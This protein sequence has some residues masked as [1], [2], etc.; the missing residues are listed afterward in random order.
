MKRPFLFLLIL[1]LFSTLSFGQS[2][3]YSLTATDSAKRYDLVSARLLNAALD[4]YPADSFS[5]ARA[6]KM[7]G[8]WQ[9]F[10]Q[11]RVAYN[12]PD[13]ISIFDPIAVGMKTFFAASN[14]TNCLGSGGGNWSFLGPKNN[15]YGTDSD[16]AGRI[17]SV[18][19][20]PDFPNI[21]LAGSASGG[22][23]R[24]TDGGQNWVNITDNGSQ[25]VPGT[26][27][28]AHIAVNPVNPDI[29]CLGAGMYFSA[30]LWNNNYG[31]GIVY[32]MDNGANWINDAQFEAKVGEVY[33]SPWETKR[34]ILRMDFS[35]YSQTLYAIYNKRIYAKSTFTNPPGFINPWSDITPPSLEGL[36]EKYHISDFR[37]TN[38]PQGR[39]VF[40]T[41]CINNTEYLFIYDES[42]GTWQ[43][44]T[45]SIP[46]RVGGPISKEGFF[47]WGIYEMALSNID[48]VYLLCNH[49]NTTATGLPIRE[50]Y[51]TDLGSGAVT[52]KCD[53]RSDDN[54]I[55]V[56]PANKD[57]IYITNAKG[58]TSF[59]SRSTNGG[60][61]F[62]YCTNGT[63]GPCNG[64]I[65]PTHADGRCILLYR[66]TNTPNGVDD[67]IYCGTDGG[68]AMKPAGSLSFHSITGNGL[69]VS[70]LYAFSSSESDDGLLV[71]GAVDNG[72]QAFVR[73]DVADQWKFPRGG[74]G[75]MPAFAKNGVLTA[76]S[77]H[78]YAIHPPM[79]FNLAN[80]EINAEDMTQPG[81]EH[82]DK[83]WKPMKFDRS[84]MARV[85]YFFIWKKSLNQIEQ[86]SPAFGI[87]ISPNEPKP[88]ITLSDAT[89]NKEL[90]AGKK[91]VQ[92]FV[93]SE[94]DTHIGY[95]A[96]GE[97]NW[98]QDPDAQTDPMEGKL[99]VATNLGDVSTPPTWNNVSPP[100][101]R[102]YPISD[103]EIDP[104]NPARVWV[105]Y[106]GAQWN[107]LNQSPS[108]R[109]GR[110]VYHSNYGD[111]SVSAWQ[112]VSKG[113]P[114]MPILK[115][116]Y[117]EGSDDLMFAATDVGIYRWNKAAAQ[118]ECFNDGMPKCMATDLE[119][120][121]CSGKLRASTMG[122]GIWETDYAP[123]VADIVPGDN[124]N[125][126]T[127]NV[128]WSSSRTLSSSV[129]VTSGNTLTIS[130]SGTKIYMPRNG[131]ILVEPHA[132]L[133]VDA[134]T[135]TNECGYSW[136]GIELVGNTAQPPIA[137]YQGTCEITNG[138][139][140]E[141]GKLRNFTG[142][143]GAKGGGIIKVDNSTFKNCWRSVELNDYPYF[144]YA[145]GGVSQCSFDNVDFVYD[146][147]L[148]YDPGVMFSTWNIRSGVL[149][150]NCTF[151]N[152]GAIGAPLLEFPVQRGTAMNIAHSGI[153]IENSF[154]NHFNRG[155]YGSD[156]SR[157]PDRIIGIYGNDFQDISENITMSVSSYSDIKS[158]TISNLAQERNS[159]G[160]YL[161]RTMGSYIGC[162]NQ[163]TGMFMT[164]LPYSKERGIISQENNIH[165]NH[166]IGNTVKQFYA[167]F[168]SQLG[169][170]KLHNLCNTYDGNN[171]ALSINP[172]SSASYNIFADQGIATEPAG[173]RFKS[174]NKDI[175]S[176]ISNS[177]NYY[178]GTGTNETPAWSGTV[179]TISSSG[180][181]RCI[182]P[183]TCYLQFGVS[184]LHKSLADYRVAVLAG[185]KSTERAQILFGDII[186][187]YNGADM[188]DSL[189]LFLETEND[190]QARR[191]LI[192]LYINR[193]KL[194]DAGRILTALTGSLPT[195]EANGYLDYYG[196]LSDLQQY[197]RPFDSL[198]TPEL[199]LMQSLA[200]DT[201]EVSPFAKA[202]LETKYNIFWEHPVENI[203]KI[204][205][206]HKIQLP[207][208]PD[209]LASILYD[210]APNPA[211]NITS[212]RVFVNN[213]D[214]KKKA[215]LVIRNTAGEQIFSSAL[216]SGENNIPVSLKGWSAGIY[217]YSLVSEKITLQTKKLSIV[218]Q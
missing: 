116:V 197:N 107:Q 149:V 151:H 178:Y 97:P 46:D 69:N 91:F 83:W 140:I 117:V 186:R 64:D 8:R 122:R 150:K 155:I 119:I 216:Q 199:T 148:L 114:I 3:P 42:L 66:T 44:K 33:P 101:L 121:Y 57:I 14:Y 51:K 132:K 88:S 24:T 103:I 45:I 126:I 99:F 56:S 187:A 4:A 92:D 218:H 214:A 163:L 78:Q 203:P 74:D 147:Q 84:N 112:D 95:I 26:M 133:I 213:M 49:K 40:S 169:N 145:V 89:A 90:K 195:N 100:Y 135:I 47:D 32:S 98:S 212:I 130:G 176:Y 110:V 50:L 59:I 36:D 160:I 28:I 190:D 15:F 144:S 158:N 189:E 125:T 67:I 129:R 5:Q 202:L 2:L 153:R 68:V 12:T 196:V 43:T 124:V 204:P 25:V 179:N 171:L 191:L 111:R 201:L 141:H 61:T 217:L 72:T 146:A 79:T 167:G 27:G 200:A 184:E 177:W 93:I 7:F 175:A 205:M 81:E 104:G 159:Y 193:N 123:N 180:A 120:E 54:H 143:N 108:L 55:A 166:I 164:F 162:N 63:T 154:F 19:V 152:E 137:A 21:I 11:N 82:Q 138:A 39:V 192:P 183:L 102:N 170:L 182:V 168:Q 194:T 96:Y 70:E 127:S 106:S 206:T 87:N 210:A 198:T 48:E 134:A 209:N 31:Y 41:N 77:Q 173:N 30:P 16:G 34:R 215:T 156:V 185:L 35:S 208:S 71:T 10:W 131:R 9:A 86:W 139:T 188:P 20:D 161:E 76:F 38:N 23:F 6:H 136:Q 94:K 52:K 1:S 172:Q 29:I 17:T 37:F 142:D 109:Q 73:H 157:S 18:W 80:G 22:L 53:L 115:L 75:L 65:G 118:W 13:S 85:G 60:S 58:N 174:N 165:H 128:T 211:D 181:N 62:S 105:A 207:S 113:L